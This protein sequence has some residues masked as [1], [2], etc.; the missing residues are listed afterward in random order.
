MSSYLILS[1]LFSMYL[2]C[3]S[4][5]TLNNIEN[6][7]LNKCAKVMSNFCFSVVT[8]TL[9]DVTYYSVKALAVTKDA[10]FFQQSC[11]PV[12]SV[13]AKQTCY[14]ECYQL[15]KTKVNRHISYSVKLFL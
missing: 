11:S 7:C 2:K 5:F 9:Y 6:Y 12:S 10:V 14:Q 3:C 13:G 1:L 4:F 15:L 8:I